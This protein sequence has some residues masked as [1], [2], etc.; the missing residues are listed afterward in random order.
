MCYTAL[1]KR[2]NFKV[3]TFVQ[4]PTFV[5]H[6][7]SSLSKEDKLNPILCG[8]ACFKKTSVGKFLF[9][10]QDFAYLFQTWS[11]RASEGTKQENT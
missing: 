9:S 1:K 8:L 4:C 5:Q 11:E 10:P 6:L 2:Y 7:L 3:S